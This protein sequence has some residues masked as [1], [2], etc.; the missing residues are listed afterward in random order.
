L[1]ALEDS[2]CR[3]EEITVSCIYSISVILE[4]TIVE[5]DDTIGENSTCRRAESTSLGDITILEERVC[6][7]EGLDFT[8]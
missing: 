4:G 6:S 1:I 7:C 5:I 3:V 2:A 8:V